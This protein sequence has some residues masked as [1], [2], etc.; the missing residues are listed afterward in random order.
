MNPAQVEPW[1]ARP[2]TQ[3]NE[4]T[5][6]HFFGGGHTLLF[7]GTGTFRAMGRDS[8]NSDAAA[9]VPQVPQVLLE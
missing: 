6:N 7:D 9:P 5:S 1:S 4:S 8:Q 2:I 3:S